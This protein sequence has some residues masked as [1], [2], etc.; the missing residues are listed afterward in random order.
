[1][2]KTRRDGQ[3][4]LSVHESAD[5]LRACEL[6]AKQVRQAAK[7][8][9][10][11]C[12][13][14]TPNVSGEKGGDAAD[15]EQ[16]RAS[17]GAKN[18]ETRNKGG[19]GAKSSKYSPEGRNLRATSGST[20]RQND[21]GGSPE[22]P[23]PRAKRFRG[24]NPIGAA[25]VARQMAEIDLRT[26]ETPKP[27]SMGAT[28]ASQAQAR[29]F[30]SPSVSGATPEGRRRRKRLEDYPPLYLE[31]V[32]R[33][34]GI[35]TARLAREHQKELDAQAKSVAEV[36]SQENGGIKK[37]ASPG[38]AE[39]GQTASVQTHAAQEVVQGRGADKQGP[40]TGDFPV[41]EEDLEIAQNLVA[42]D[43]PQQSLHTEEAQEVRRST[44][45]A[46]GSLEDPPTSG[47][48]EEPLSAHELAV[49]AAMKLLKGRLL[50]LDG[51]SMGDLEGRAAGTE[52]FSAHHK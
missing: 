44:E 17:A 40:E 3:Q 8:G 2:T 35:D 7:R 33:G 14:V 45:D 16:R 20:Q 50:G 38:V 46:E 15:M 39:E 51:W 31:A 23:A 48:G 52:E 34:L 24:V 12:D 43:E 42:S 21:P 49:N 32:A 47:A 27:V 26:P 41:V 1:M 10:Q 18:K 29:L 36:A 28:Q 6:R 37:R 25:T 9:H 11:D 4:V 13:Q 19:P 5:I 22:T 30:E